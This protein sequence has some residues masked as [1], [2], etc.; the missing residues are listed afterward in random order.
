MKKVEID[1][2]LSYLGYFFFGGG[3]GLHKNA[4]SVIWLIHMNFFPIENLVG[5]QK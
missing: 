5:F 4:Y 1:I 3:G 2:F